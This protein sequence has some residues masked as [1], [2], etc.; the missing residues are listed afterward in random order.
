MSESHKIILSYNF[1]RCLAI[2]LVILLSYN[3]LSSK[4]YKSYYAYR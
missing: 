1:A 3:L 2:C 4:Q